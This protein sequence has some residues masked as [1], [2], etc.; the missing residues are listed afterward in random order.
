MANLW[1][2]SG[3]FVTAILFRVLLYGEGQ[4]GDPHSTNVCKMSQLCGAISLLFLSNPPS[5]L[6]DVLI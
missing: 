4:V 1:L 3:S 5:I 6:A 2:L